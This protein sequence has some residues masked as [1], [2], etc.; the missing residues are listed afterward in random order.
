MRRNGNLDGVQI[1]EDDVKSKYSVRRKYILRTNGLLG[2]KRAKSMKKTR[3]HGFSLFLSVKRAL[4][5]AL[6]ES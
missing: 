6:N 5:T 2:V 3:M 4:V 1:D